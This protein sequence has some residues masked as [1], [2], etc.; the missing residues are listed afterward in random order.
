MTMTTTLR[1]HEQTLDE[2]RTEVRANVRAEVRAEVRAGAMAIAPLFLGYAPF[3]L[4]IGSAVAAH[5]DPLAGCDRPRGRHHPG[6]DPRPAQRLPPAEAPP[7]LTL[8]TTRLRG[9]PTWPVTPD[10]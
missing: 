5:G 9:E 4:V 8:R 2:P 7:R 10:P 3:A 1:A 6:R